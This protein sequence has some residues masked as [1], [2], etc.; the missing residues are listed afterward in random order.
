MVKLIA[1]Y[2]TPENKEEFDKHYNEMHTPLVKKIPG[3]RKLE[4]AKIT[5]APIGEPKHYL[6]AEM[7]FDNQDAMNA[8]LASPEGKAT[9]RDLMSFAASI[10]T[11]FFA[12]VEKG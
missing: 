11:M 7:Y 9:A 1:M 4:V 5:G 12:E 3:L 6:I 8:A 10:V 2:K